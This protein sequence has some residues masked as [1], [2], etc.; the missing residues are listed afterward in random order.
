[1]I[2]AYL[3]HESERKAQGIP[4]KPL[5]PEQTRELVKLLENPPKGQEAFLLVAAARPRLPRRGRGRRGEGARSSPTSSPGK[6]KCPLVSRKEAVRAARHDDGRLQRAAARRRAEG[7]RARRRRREGA[8]PHDLRLRR[9]RR[10]ARAL[11]DQ[12]RPRRRWSSAW[13]KAEW[14]TSRPGVPET[15][16]LKVF[17]VDGEINTDDFS[18]AGDASTRP[19]IPLHALAMG[20]TRFPARPRR[21]SPSSAPHGFQVAFVGDVVGTGSSRKSACNSRAVAHRRGHPVRAR[22]SGAAA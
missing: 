6:K 2:E 18:P 15:L 16:K 1:M 9:L 11:E 3:K 10:R 19:D 20:K 14:F 4:P 7:R 12:R 8:L 13:A 21:R 5:D 22:T 17:K